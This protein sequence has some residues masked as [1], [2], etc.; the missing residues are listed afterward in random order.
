MAEVRQ[1]DVLLWWTDGKAHW[2][3]TQPLP[4]PFHFRL[5]AVHSERD[6]G[7]S[8]IRVRVDCIEPMNGWPRSISA[9]RA[10]HGITDALR[11]ALTRQLQD[12]QRN[13]DRIDVS[14]IQTTV[15]GS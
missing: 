7:T 4:Q 12:Q 11:N 1:H 2:S 14:P 6:P 5:I 15:L 8:I 3:T 9:R 13:G 10:K